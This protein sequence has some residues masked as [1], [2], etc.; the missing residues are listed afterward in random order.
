MKELIKKTLEKLNEQYVEE[1]SELKIS[2]F[3]K[4][5]EERIFGAVVIEPW[6]DVTPEGDAH[7]DKMTA[8]EIEKSAHGF[9]LNGATTGWMHVAKANAK[10]I[11]SY[12]APVDY[13]PEGSEEVIK[14][15]SWVLVVKVFDDT[16]WEMIQK[17]EITAFSPGGSGYRRNVKEG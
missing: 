10:V 7:G 16:L 3:K 15:G 12:I 14:K 11:E 6:T 9:M 8:E 4:D 5:T 2:V 17:G 1:G 13:T